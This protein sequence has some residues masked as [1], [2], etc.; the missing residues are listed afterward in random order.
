MDRTLYKVPKPVITT[1][2]RWKEMDN[3]YKGPGITPP[4]VNKET[5]GPGAYG[6]PPSTFSPA[7]RSNK[8][9]CGFGTATAHTTDI[10]S[11]DLPAP[12]AY[13]PKAIAQSGAVAGKI[14]KATR[15]G[16]AKSYFGAGA[17]QALP[18]DT[19][20]PG[21]YSIPSPSAVLRS[22]SS[23]QLG[24][25]LSGRRHNPLTSPIATAKISESTHL[26]L[27]LLLLF[28]YTGG[29]WW[30]GNGWLDL[31][32]CT[33]ATVESQSTSP[34]SQENSL[35]DISGSESDVSVPA[36][37]DHGRPANTAGHRP[38]GEM[39]NGVFKQFSRTQVLRR[40]D[41]E[42]KKAKVKRRHLF[43]QCQTGMEGAKRDTQSFAAMCDGY[44]RPQT[45][46]SAPESVH[47]SLWSYC[48]C[49]NPVAVLA[50]LNGNGVHRA[51][52][53]ELALMYVSASPASQ[54]SKPE[55]EQ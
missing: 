51:F 34:V 7:K 18:M 6:M 39:V 25:S 27:S 41:K 42:F 47:C 23:K 5:P 53:L 33:R 49:V 30:L 29:A 45:T 13:H 3:I 35:A 36:P 52:S 15:D 10:E 40:M 20:G 24:S 4:V 2:D 43:K 14:A 9:P 1:G 16:R 38:I 48:G 55:Q 8:S 17:P 31:R 21:S 22:A 44:L 37:L 50:L 26:L 19:P 46:A 12:G 28:C 11:S 54:C 32:I